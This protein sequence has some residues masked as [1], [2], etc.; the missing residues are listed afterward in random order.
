M[1]W[2]TVD[3]HL[4]EHPKMAELPSDAA[5][6]GWIVVLTKAK[7]QRQPGRFASERHFKEVLGRHAKHLPSYRAAGLMDADGD[8]L[9]IH[10][11]E[12]HQWK[13]A[14]AGQ[15]EDNCESVKRGHFRSGQQL[16]ATGAGTAF[17][18]REDNGETNGGQEKDSRAGSV[19]P[20]PVYSS[21]A[22]GE[23]VQGERVSL[24]VPVK[25]LDGSV[26]GV[27]VTDEQPPSDVVLLQRLA[28][29]LTGQAYVMHNVHGGLGAK[30]VSE[31]LPHGFD[32]VQRAWRQIAS[33]AKAEGSNAPTLRQLVF[34]ADDILNPIP[35]SA[36]LQRADREADEAQRKARREKRNAE[37]LRYLR[38]MTEGG[39]P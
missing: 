34:G 18:Q 37:Q 8:A 36:Q 9:V 25:G 5:R 30:A 35:S 16:V 20:V 2:I 6:W 32:R 19:V 17:G 11:W 26:T 31:Q 39:T 10:D 27:D 15:R 3:C 21:V 14:K 4:S 38:S 29:E 1:P 28:E 13:V 12:R 23:G 24:V 7:L 33:R 22:P